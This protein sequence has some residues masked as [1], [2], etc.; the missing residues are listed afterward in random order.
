MGL[1]LQEGAPAP[2]SETSKWKYRLHVFLDSELVFWLGSLRVR[3]DS[4]VMHVAQTEWL[5]HL[6]AALSL[7]FPTC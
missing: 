4:Q 2:R 7:L 5:H 6:Q 3:G 1:L